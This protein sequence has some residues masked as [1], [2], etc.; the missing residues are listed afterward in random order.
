ML[1]QSGD[2]WCE[3]LNTAFAKIFAKERRQRQRR[4]GSDMAMTSIIAGRSGT[5]I[6]E[7]RTLLRMGGVGERGW[8]GEGAFD[9]SHNV[10]RKSVS[11]K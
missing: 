8:E 11:Q 2:L 9:S 6:A 7:H 10:E 5:A 4:V 3:R 1:S